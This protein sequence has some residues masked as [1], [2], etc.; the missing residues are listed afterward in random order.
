MRRPRSL[1]FK[2]SVHLRNNRKGYLHLYLPNSEPE[3]EPT[4]VPLTSGLTLPLSKS[5]TS[6]GSQ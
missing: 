6:T 3:S 5:Y 2:D 1:A 4:S